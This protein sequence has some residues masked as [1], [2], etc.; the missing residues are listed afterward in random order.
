MFAGRPIIGLV[1]GIGSGKSFVASLFGEAGCL[2]IDS[3][4]Q[5]KAAYE[6]DD[7]KEVLRSWWADEVFHPDGTVDRVAVARIVF[8]NE[9]Q[10][11]RL[12]DLLHPL[13]GQMRDRAMEEAAGNPAIKAYIWDTP[14]LVETGLAGRCDVLVF[15]D[16]PLRQREGRVAAERGWKAGELREREKLQLP[17]DKKR[18]MA[19]YIVRNTAGAGEVRSQVREL[20]S[21]ILAGFS[22]GKVSECPQR[23]D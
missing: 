22:D 17:L 9:A 1:G 2:V 12:E 21:R 13:V 7:V 3:D 14:L 6:R 18:K 16:A 4:L 19:N 15:V 8:R 20:L 5:V 10:R 11:R 23:A